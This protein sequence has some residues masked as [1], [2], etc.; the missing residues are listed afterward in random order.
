MSVYILSQSILIKVKN[1]IYSR[2]R[3]EDLSIANTNA[4][5]KSLNMFG[6]AGSTRVSRGAWA[7]MLVHVPFSIVSEFL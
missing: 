5:G 2:E 1:H 3:E 4:V 7:S 6:P